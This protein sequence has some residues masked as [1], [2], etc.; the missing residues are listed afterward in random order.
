MTT[1]SATPPLVLMVYGD[2]A[3]GYGD[4]LRECGFRVVE[5]HTASDALSRAL[6]M[7]PDLI[8]LDYDLDGDVVAH[9]RSNMLTKGVPIIALTVLSTLHERRRH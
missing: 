5:A 6:K 7:M 2:V 8:V 9:L 3:G 4:Y 1:S